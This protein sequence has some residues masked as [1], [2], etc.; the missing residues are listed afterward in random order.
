ML[1]MEEGEEGGRGRKGRRG[2]RE[3]GR[4]MIMVVVLEVCGVVMKVTIFQFPQ[5]TTYHLPLNTHTHTTHTT[6]THTHTHTHTQHTT[7]IHI[8]Y[9]AHPIKV[10]STYSYI[11]TIRY[12]SKRMQHGVNTVSTRCGGT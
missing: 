2:E 9:S 8:P 11:F 3:G 12:A 7:H 5:F 6:H 1:H 4:G 10:P